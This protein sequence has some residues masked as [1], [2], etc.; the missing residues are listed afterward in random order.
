MQVPDVTGHFARIFGA[1]DD[2]GAG[3]FDDSGCVSF[4]SGKDRFPCGEV[5][6]EFVRY[7]HLEQVVASQVNHTHIGDSV[8]LGHSFFW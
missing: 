2:A 4:H 8:Q 3:F 1:A 7:R 5:R 6:Q